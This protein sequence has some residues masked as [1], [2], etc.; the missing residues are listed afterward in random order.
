MVTRVLGT[1]TADPP[2]KPGDCFFVRD[3]DIRIPEGGYVCLWALQNL[4][5]VVTPKEREIAEAKDEDWMWRVHHVQCPDPDGRVIFKIERVSKIQKGAMEGK[6]TGIVAD[7]LEWKCAVDNSGERAGL[8]DLR[9]V[10]EEVR[11]RCTSGMKP[12]DYFVLRS[13]RLYI[14]AHRHFCLYALHATLPML[15]AKQRYLADGDWLRDADRLICPDPAGNVIMRVE[16][17]SSGSSLAGEA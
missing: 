11:G 3:G 2:M 5:P 13:G 12:G 15:P 8:R 6:N 1:C 7:A 16:R 14:P 17:C 4:L 9:I 10:V